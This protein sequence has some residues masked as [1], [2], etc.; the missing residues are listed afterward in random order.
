M[1]QEISSVSPGNG[2][3]SDLYKE[4]AMLRSEMAAINRVQA[5]IEFDL[6][7]HVLTANNN[8]LH[9]MGYTLEEVRGKHHR[10]FVKPEFAASSEYQQFW[11]NLRAGRAD[12]RVFDRYTKHGGRVWIQAS[13]N[14]ILD[15]SGKPYKV[16]KFAT[17]LTKIIDQTEQTQQ[18]AQQVAAATE[19]LSSSIG[20]ISSNMEKSREATANIIHISTE[21]GTAA[22]NL[23][24]SMHAMEKI[25]GLIR[26]IA[27]RVNML[28]LNATIEAARAGEAGRGF[29]VVAGEVKNLSDQTSKATNQIGKEIATVQQIAGKVAESIN[30]TIAGIQHVGEY[31]NGVATA[32]T[33]QTAVTREISEHSSHMVKAVENILTEA[34]GRQ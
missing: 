20:E 30:Q 32:M 4:L 12:V 17:D 27:G 24:E 29:A 28:A 22:G 15:E 2:N 10:I 1:T 26:D 19:E 34:R 14:P 25:V 7:G 3:T 5:V 6:D 13:Y 8:F 23:T 18:T 33:Q 31:V 21:S 9:L 11:A 16:V